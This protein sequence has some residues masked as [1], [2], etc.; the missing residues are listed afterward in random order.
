M[1]RRSQALGRLQL[2]RN[3]LVVGNGRPYHITEGE[4]D[5]LVRGGK[6]VWQKKGRRIKYTMG[7]HSRPEV[8]GLSC[9]D[10]GEIA[11]ALRDRDPGVRAVAGA[12]LNDQ[13]R[14]RESSSRERR[15]LHLERVNGA[16]VDLVRDVERLECERKEDRMVA[17]MATGFL[18]PEV[19]EG[20]SQ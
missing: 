8:R 11:G 5:R 9:F 19:R 2:S 14:R 1:V 15:R 4:A 13:F 18:S 16:Y 12:F 20:E 7:K 6:A 10:G 17:V 3:V